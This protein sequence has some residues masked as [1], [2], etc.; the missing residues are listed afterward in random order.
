MG[1]EPTDA[2][3]AAYLGWVMLNHH[4]YGRSY[5]VPA[6]A[7]KTVASYLSSAGKRIHASFRLV[8]PPGNST[9]FLDW[10]DVHDP[11]ELQATVIIAAHGDSVLIEVRDYSDLGSSAPFEYFM[12]RAAGG[13]PPSMSP[14]PC[15]YLPTPWDRGDSG[16]AQMMESRDTC[17]LRRG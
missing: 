8:A 7:N 16:E 17:L 10:P 4:G 6:D 3:A 5:C 13:G 2:P 1:S 11:E 15:C 9:L 12:Y 14:L